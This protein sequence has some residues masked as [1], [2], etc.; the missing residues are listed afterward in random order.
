MSVDESSSSSSRI[1]LSPF[2]YK[3]L[4]SLLNIFYRNSLGLVDL[5]IEPLLLEWWLYYI[6]D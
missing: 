5:T 3:L 1:F 4:E 2:T 6:T